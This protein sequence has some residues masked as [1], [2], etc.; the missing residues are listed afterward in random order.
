MAK[1]AVCAAT[2]RVQTTSPCLG[3]RRR[4]GGADVL[5][6]AALWWAPAAMRATPRARR[7][8]MGVG[9]GRQEAAERPSRP[10]V[11]QPH[12][13]TT[14]FSKGGEGGLA[15][16]AVMITAYLKTKIRTC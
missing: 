16:K 3:K 12:A 4:G 5:V 9:V 8:G 14:P 13:K 1:S 6:T 7:G 10:L 2:P 15:M 11:P